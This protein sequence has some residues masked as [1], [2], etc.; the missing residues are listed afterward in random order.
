MEINYVCSFGE[1]CHTATFLKR[2]GL[3]LVSYPFD[4]IYSGIDTIIHCVDDDFKIFL[5]KKYYQDPEIKYKNF[6]N[7][8]GHSFYHPNFFNHKDPRKEE[9]YNY[10][11]RCIDRFRNLLKYKEHKLFV[12]MF[13]N[14]NNIDE[15]IKNSVIEFNKKISEYTSN[16]TLLTIFHLSNK[17]CNYHNFTYNHNIHFL[18]LH[19]FSESYGSI[20]AY[21]N[22]DIYLDNIIKKTYNFNIIA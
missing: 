21:I 15:D 1:R 9:H 17:R 18:E 16:Y 2:M 10:Y 6:D 7:Q 12:I 4:W 13:L 19:T 5:E 22:D 3:K 8:C 20:F 14:M 11:I